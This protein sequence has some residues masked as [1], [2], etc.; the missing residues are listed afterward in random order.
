MDKWAQTTTHRDAPWINVPGNIRGFRGRG[1]SLIEVTAVLVLMGLMAVGTLA[2]YR[3]KARG[4]GLDDVMGK[5]A[6]IDA[7]ARQM[8]LR[9]GQTVEVR[10]DLSAGIVVLVEPNAGTDRLP[11]VLPSTMKFD[12][13]ETAESGTSSGPVSVPVTAQGVSPSYAVWVKSVDGTS[14]TNLVAGLT[15]QVTRYDGEDGWNHAWATVS[16]L[17]VD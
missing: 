2:A 6:L 1:F 4:A 15:G 16:S 9:S 8:A 13:I 7:Q 17:D 12:R 14:A 10:F 11:L 5:L 3:V